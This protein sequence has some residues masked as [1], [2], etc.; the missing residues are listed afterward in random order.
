MRDHM[1]QIED[2]ME[3]ADKVIESKS[4]VISNNENEREQ[5]RTH[6]L[7]QTQTEWNAS[8]KP[9][10]CIIDPKL[11]DA[12]LFWLVVYLPSLVAHLF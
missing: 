3:E 7:H 2:S 4:M 9:S 11:F 6:Q 10:V 12:A 1:T 8:F 5:T